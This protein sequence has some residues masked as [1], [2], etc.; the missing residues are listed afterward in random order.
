MP[1]RALKTK[2]T[3]PTW[4]VTNA[5]TQLM[6]IVADQCECC[7]EP[8][9][10]RNL[11]K[12]IVKLWKNSQKYVKESKVRN[13]TQDIEYCLSVW[14]DELNRIYRRRIFFTQ[15]FNYGGLD[16]IRTSAFLIHQVWQGCCWID[17][18]PENKEN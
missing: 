13:M 4:L 16:R 18:D 2:L 15:R 5:L 10:F 11:R 12:I 3:G 7:M 14:N 17:H 9:D 8:E 1:I 6:V